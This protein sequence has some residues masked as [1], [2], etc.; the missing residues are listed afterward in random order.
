LEAAAAQPP[1]SSKLSLHFPW[2]NNKDKDK[3]KSSNK[4]KNAPAASLPQQH[5]DEGQEGGDIE[6]VQQLVVMGFPRDQAVQAL[7][8][9]GFDVQRALNSLLSAQ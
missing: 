3:T 6:G 2:G 4:D 9:N 1:R 7:E 5:D 8:A